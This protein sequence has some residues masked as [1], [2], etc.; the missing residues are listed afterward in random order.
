MDNSDLKIDRWN[1]KGRTS[2]IVP[3]KDANA[4]YRA[5]LIAARL[6]EHPEVKH[7]DGPHAT[8]QG[9]Q[10]S[11]YGTLRGCARAIAAATE[12]PAP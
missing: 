4:S 10:I 2:V 5:A 12:P 3:G 8:G 9:F 7:V 11:A 1:G 6:R